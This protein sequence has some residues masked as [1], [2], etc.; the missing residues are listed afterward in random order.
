MGATGGSSGAG[1]GGAAGEDAGRSDDDAG[2]VG[3]GGHDGG[4]GGMGGTSAG[5]TITGMVMGKTFDKVTTALWIGKPDRN[6]PPTTVVYLFDASV[7]CSEISAVGWDGRIKA[8]QVLEMKTGGTT[9]GKYTIRGGMPAAVIAGEAAT[10]H[11]TL[12]GA[13]P[14][15]QFAS[16]GTVTLTEVNAAKDATGSFDLMFPAGGRLA[17]TF[18]AT[19]CP[20]GVEP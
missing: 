13:M 7:Q 15:E 14:I 6:T 12:G 2:Q 20:A 18:N 5:S 11:S 8:M 10:N 17:G 1:G 16:G 9:P 19:W 3:Q 4:S